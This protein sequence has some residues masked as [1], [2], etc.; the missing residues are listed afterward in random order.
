MRTHVFTQ[1]IIFTR[2]FTIYTY[3]HTLSRVLDFGLRI[4]GGGRGNAHKNACTHT[5]IYSRIYMY[6]CTHMA[7]ITIRVCALREITKRRLGHTHKSASS[8]SSR[9]PHTTRRT[10]ILSRTTPAGPART[11]TTI[12]SRPRTRTTRL[13]TRAR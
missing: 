9:P 8:R 11:T 7:I 2:P 1:Y 10:H 3:I 6:I 13:D 5:I 12:V 4:G